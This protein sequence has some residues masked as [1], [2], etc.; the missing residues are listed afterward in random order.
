MADLVTVVVIAGQHSFFG[1][2]EN[3]GLRV[4]EL[5]NDVSSNYL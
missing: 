5:L 2:L 1:G 4:L 3:R